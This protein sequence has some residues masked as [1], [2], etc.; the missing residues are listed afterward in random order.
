[1]TV[2]LKPVTAKTPK[3]L[4]QAVPM[5]TNNHLMR[6]HFIIKSMFRQM[7]ITNKLILFFK[8][9]CI[10]LIM[11]CLNAELPHKD[12]LAVNC[13][14]KG[15]STAQYSLCAGLLCQSALE[16]CSPSISG[17]KDTLFF[18]GI[19]SKMEDHRSFSERAEVIKTGQITDLA[20]CVTK[21][22]P[23]PNLSKYSPGANATTPS[24]SAGLSPASLITREAE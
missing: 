13:L 20:L 3:M 22:F 4:N 12:Y 14:R 19:A 16:P 6:H 10:F 9:H 24:A 8:F 5:W 11:P 17:R 7:I 2:K 23:L 15:I 21:V 18:E 1:M